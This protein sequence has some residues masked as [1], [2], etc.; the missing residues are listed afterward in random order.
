VYGKARRSAMRNLKNGKP[1]KVVAI[2]KLEGQGEGRPEE[3]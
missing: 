3:G 2:H 1:L